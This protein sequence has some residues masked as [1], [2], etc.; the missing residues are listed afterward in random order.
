MEIYMII[1]NFDKIEENNGFDLAGFAVGIIENYIF[2]KTDKIKR[3][4]I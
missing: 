4:I 3:R 2:P 1:F